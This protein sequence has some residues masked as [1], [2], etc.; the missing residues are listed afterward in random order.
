LLQRLIAKDELRN[1]AAGMLAAAYRIKLL[2]R[3]DNPDPV[4]IKLA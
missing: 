3:Q 4:K 1:Q 2:R